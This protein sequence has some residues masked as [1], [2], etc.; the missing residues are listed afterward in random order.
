MKTN[1]VIL[2][3]I[4][5]KYNIPEKKYTYAKKRVPLKIHGL[6]DCSEKKLS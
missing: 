5:S 1:I 4:P 6:I 3:D 2:V